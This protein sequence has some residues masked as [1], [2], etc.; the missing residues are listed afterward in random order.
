MLSAGCP[1][2]QSPVTESAGEWSCPVHGPVPV[3]WRAT[4]PSYD[5][6]V[7]H[8]ER[9]GHFPTYL[10]W[11]MA[12]GWHVSDFGVVRDAVG[13]RATVTGTSG[14]S[15]LDGPVDVLVVTE[16]PGTGLGG[17]VARLVSSDPTG[18]GEGSPIAKVRVDAASV[19]LWQVST[20]AADGEFDRMVLAGE[21]QGRWLWLVLRPASAVLLLRDEWILRDVA[22]A[23]PGLVEMEFGGPA[24]TW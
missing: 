3:L 5:A 20:S 23:G 19:S 18:V 7:A 10:P 24:P 1:R 13:P 2:C 14:T 9:A 17:R 15:V 21:A 8:L 6:L 22:A 16:E 12:A 11:P 4:T